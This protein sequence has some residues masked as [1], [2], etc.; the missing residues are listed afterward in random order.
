MPKPTVEKVPQLDVI[1]TVEGLYGRIFFGC[2][3]TLSGS[4]LLLLKKFHGLLCRIGVGRL[5]YDD[6]YLSFLF[7]VCMEDRSQSVDLG[8]CLIPS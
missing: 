3:W 4:L 8:V 1:V 2:S 7:P 6:S 5:F